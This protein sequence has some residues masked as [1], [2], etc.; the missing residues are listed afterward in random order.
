MSDI[1]SQRDNQ[2]N[3]DADRKL[4]E[5]MTVV[6]E[7]NQKG[8]DAWKSFQSD[9]MVQGR[10]IEIT[11]KNRDFY[12]RNLD[13]TLAAMRDANQANLQVSLEGMR[14]SGAGDRQGKGFAHDNEMADKANQAKEMLMENEATMALFSR[15]RAAGIDMAGEKVKAMITTMANLTPDSEGYEEKKIQFDKMQ[16]EFSDILNETVDFGKKNADGSMDLPD[17]V[18]VM[19]VA[20]TTD[21][22]E[23]RE[24]LAIGQDVFEGLT[25]QFEKNPGA[26]DA[27]GMIKVAAG[28]MTEDEWGKIRRK[29]QPTD[30]ITIITGTAANILGTL[31]KAGDS[32][33]AKML[34]SAMGRKKFTPPSNGA[35]ASPQAPPPRTP[36]GGQRPQTAGGPPDPA[37]NQSA[38]ASPRSSGGRYS[39]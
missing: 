37:P 33:L 13:R 27:W 11:E 19:P 34:E 15:A 39:F 14:Q 6:A 38:A 29:L 18:P 5:R 16:K 17:A 9:F 8:E 20:L 36:Q 35:P 10:M 31:A 22:G 26:V 1:Q 23:P 25:T 28:E 32:I 30:A 7:K 3:L 2:E 24:V 4:Q 21:E 12:E